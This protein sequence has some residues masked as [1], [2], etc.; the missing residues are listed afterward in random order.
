M[1]GLSDYAAEAVLNW[2]S[3]CQ[4]MP[5]LASR[6]LALFT[7]APTADAGTGGT[8]VSGGSYARVQVAG[9]VAATASWT[10][11]VAT[12][13]VGAGLTWIVAG[14]NVYDTTNSQQIGTVSTYA[15]TTLTLTGNAS[16]A[17]SGS[18]D[19]LQ[20]SAWP[21]SSASSGSEPATAPASVTNSGATI[22]FAQATA[23]WSTVVAWALYDALSSGNMVC[24]DYL[25]N[26]KWVPFTCT[27]ANPGVLTTDL[28][29]DVPVN[30]SSCVVTQ[31]FGGT[32]PSGTWTGLLTS[33][34]SSGVTFNLGVNSTGTAGGG[35]FRQV[36][37]QPIAINVTASFST[38]TLT[39]SLA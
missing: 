37:Q 17:S 26:N 39:L 5:A 21:A 6:Y 7:T 15:G 25:G 34:G 20:I 24:W 9:T 1:A 29:A 35:Q 30:G 8:E 23:S 31:K 18:T 28:V 22:T 11:S 12:I 2:E 10:T 33:G 4:P 14:M 13:S 3:G 38:S 36:T 16:H 27:A 32:L 19:N